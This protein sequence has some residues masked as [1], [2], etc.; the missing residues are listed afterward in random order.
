MGETASR[1]VEDITR[2]EKDDTPLSPRNYTPILP[3]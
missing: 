2:V 3:N 1:A